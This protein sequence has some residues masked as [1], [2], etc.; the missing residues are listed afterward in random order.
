LNTQSLLAFMPFPALSAFVL[1][2]LCIAGMSYV[3]PAIHQAIQPFDNSVYCTPR[4]PGSRL[5]SPLIAN[6]WG[7]LLMRAA[8]QKKALVMFAAAI[9]T[10]CGGGE[11]ADGGSAD[12]QNADPGSV[13]TSPASIYAEAYPAPAYAE[14]F[15]FLNQASMGATKAEA[16][17]VISMGYEAWIDEQ[18]Q[19]PATLA[20]PYTE[21][22]IQSNVD[23]DH[24]HSCRVGAWV[25]NALYGPDQLRQRVAL[26]LSEILVISQVSALNWYKWEPGLADYYDL[27]AKNAFGNY[28][29]LIEDVTLH[30]A[31]GKYLSMKGNLKPDIENNIRPD[32][33]FSRELMQ[34]FTIGLFELNVDGSEKRNE[35]GWRIPTYR[36]ATVQGFAHVFTGWDFQLNPGAQDVSRTRPMIL[37]PNRHDTGQ[38]RL[39]SGVILSERADGQQDLQDAL[40]NVF[41]HPNVAPFVSLRLIQRLV[42]SNPSRAYVARVA[43]VF[44]DNGVGV[45]GDLAAVVKAILLDPEARPALYSP[46][47]GKLKEPM[48]RLTQL[49]RAYGGKTG[50]ASGKFRLTRLW[51]KVGQGPLQA[52][53]VFNFFLPSYAPTGQIRD[54]QLV[55]PEMQIATEYQVA[56]LSSYF[57]RQTHKWNT[58]SAIPT[59]DGAVDVLINI[60]GDINL[61]ANPDALVGRVA[62][63]LLGGKISAELRTEVANLI[64][65][66]PLDTVGK[67]NSA[68]IFLIVSSPEYA[69]QY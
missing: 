7:W 44:N 40:D 39:L 13:P 18:L 1:A 60:N 27:L 54:Q 30:P 52:E 21:A 5:D 19:I 42:S 41:Q 49:W 16:R 15:R 57:Y 53:S 50:D 59:S 35:R 56:L 28:R 31:M 25:K 2:T 36:Q 22:C 69:Y 65:K 9:L 45:K 63:R 20:L 46:I 10:A 17:N 47:D 38:K 14:A 58:L 4:R 51:V 62:S 3:W 6:K 11:G 37:T 64:A 48:L 61:A 34:L 26:A 23:M 66:I 24:G 67:R 43:H 68:A 29:D 12:I 55:A 32:E 8:I 33:N